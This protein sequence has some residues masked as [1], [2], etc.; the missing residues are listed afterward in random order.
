[1]KKTLIFVIFLLS[2]T[3]NLN[4][5]IINKSA[6]YTR[7]DDST[8]GL[9]D[10]VQ[11]AL[12]NLD[13]SSGGISK[14]DATVGTTGADYTTIS[15]AIATG[16]SRLLLVD[17]VTET[18]SFNMPD[19]FLLEG[20]GKYGFNLNMGIY[21]FLDNSGANQGFDIINIKITFAYTVAGNLFNPNN[22]DTG[23]YVFENV[24]FDNNSTVAS[25]LVFNN[26]SNNCKTFAN[27]IVL[28]LPNFN[29]CGWKD[30]H[31]NLANFF[32]IGGGTNCG[33][34]LILSFANVKG[35]SFSGTFAT[36]ITTIEGTSSVISNISM[37]GN[38]TIGRLEITDC[39]ISG[40]NLYAG[41]F[42]VEG[43]NNNISNCHTGTI[44][45]PSGSN[46]NNFSNF[47][48]TGTVSVT[49]NDTGITGCTLN[50]LT[51]NSGATRTRIGLTATNT[52]ISD[53]GTGTVGVG[54]IVY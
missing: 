37:E 11:E 18:A 34:C 52:A 1:M 47:R 44:T 38:I 39:D 31:S 15:A 8:T 20:T 24:Y 46:F 22:T 41:A 25:S 5:G 21:K 17:D 28:D 54:N 32:I 10:N 13:A 16:K 4:A 7:Y 30:R 43:D 12:D 27:D 49:G 9:G 45:V 14:Y 50:A 2:F 36:S 53:S 42:Y 3:M 26:T 48:T 19:N 23:K 29:G 6:K 33:D 35:I 40:V 51:I